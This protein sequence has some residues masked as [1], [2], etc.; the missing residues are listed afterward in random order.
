MVKTF[1]KE[2]TMSK[3]YIIDY[4]T[5]INGTISDSLIKVTLDGFIKFKNSPNHRYSRIGKI[6]Q[7]YVDDNNMRTICVESIQNIK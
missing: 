5:F 4:E 6:I 2:F 3:V 7:D 1:K